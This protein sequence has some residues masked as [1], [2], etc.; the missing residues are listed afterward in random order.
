MKAKVILTNISRTNKCLQIKIGMQ[1]S[2]VTTNILK[3]V[4]LFAMDEF[5][6]NPFMLECLFC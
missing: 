2:V 5:E 6:N 4:C 3:L 1:T